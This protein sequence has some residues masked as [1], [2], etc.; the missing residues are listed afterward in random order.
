M[1]KKSKSNILSFNDKN[2]I[3]QGGVTRATKLLQLAQNLISTHVK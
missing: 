1:E 3:R 2:V